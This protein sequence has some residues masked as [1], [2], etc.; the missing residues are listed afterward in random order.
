MD[1]ARLFT[2]SARFQERDFEFLASIVASRGDQ[3]AFRRFV[4]DPDELLGVL[5]DRRVLEEILESP[6]LLGVSPPFYFSVLVRHSLV[7]RGLENVELAE[8][9][10]AVLADRI[11]SSKLHAGLGPGAGFVH[12]FDLLTM[13]DQVSGE[14]RF[15]L[16]ITAGNEF[17]VLTG[18]FPE[19]IQQRARRKGA[20]GIDYYEEFARASYQQAGEHPRA[21]ES[22]VSGVLENLSR[23]LPEARL[24]LNR[25]ADS[26]VFLSN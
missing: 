7:S 24:S 25:I 12:S 5:D 18:L 20:P 2:C 16:L 9:L 15:E 14:M 6:S 22:G 17:L 3:D 1:K 21:R 10:G 26:L 13:L 4:A 11:P 8:F 23:V 19:Y